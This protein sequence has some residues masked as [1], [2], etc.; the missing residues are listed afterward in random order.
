MATPV[1]PS[2]SVIPSPSPFNVKEQIVGLGVFLG[3]NAVVAVLGALS[4]INSA[5]FYNNELV[6]PV[7]AP[8]SWL[9]GPVWT[10]LY[11]MIAVSAW[12]VWRQNGWSTLVTKAKGASGQVAT[13]EDGEA[14][15]ADDSSAAADKTKEDED[16]IDKIVASLPP[17]LVV[18]FA[19]LVVNTVWTYI[20]FVKKSGAGALA[21]IVVL[22][23]MVAALILLFSRRER[24][25]LAVLLLLPYFAWS[26][27]ATAL[28]Y[29]VWELN[30]ALLGN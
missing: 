16:I 27:F 6:K 1:K 20:F 7:W 11:I 8:P 18:Y 2:P 22:D 28:T 12:L 14:G 4:S 25:D 3:I 30:P 29:S 24:C 26:V 15:A 23:V 19:Q 13:L 10:V 17:S 9:F 21:D 5:T